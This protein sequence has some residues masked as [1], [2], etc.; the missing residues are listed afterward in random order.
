MDT[1]RKH[2]RSGRVADTAIRVEIWSGEDGKAMVRAIQVGEFPP[3]TYGDGELR[4]DSADAA[5]ALA[6]RTVQAEL[7]AL[8]EDQVGAARD[9]HRDAS[10]D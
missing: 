1:T 3:T 2:W 5:F 7:D 10:R 6:E 8:P 4:A 9:P